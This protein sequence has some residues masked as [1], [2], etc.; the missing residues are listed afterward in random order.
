MQKYPLVF[1]AGRL[2]YL[3]LI[4][5]LRAGS[6]WI[7][8]KTLSVNTGKVLLAADENNSFT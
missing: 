6:D 2:S 7:R 8:D 4:F 5:K 1:H 3:Q